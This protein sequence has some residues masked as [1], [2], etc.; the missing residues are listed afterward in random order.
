M[1][2]LLDTNV[3]VAAKQ[4]YYG[5]RL[6]PGFWEWVVKANGHGTVLS[7]KQVLD[8]LTAL[9]D[10]L[11]S[12][13][14]KQGNKLFLPMDTPTVT[15][16][17]TVTSWV[18][19]GQFRDFAKEDFLRG[20]DPFLIAYAMAHNHTI[21]TEEVFVQHTVRRV[22]IPEVCIDLGVPYLTTFEMLS[23]EGVQFVLK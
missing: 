1:A 8:E 22:R 18:M 10:D 7:H 14:S 12:W 21:V 4:R 5:F 19:K 11:A 15:A 6:C 16:M 2:Y 3:F 9:A 17:K 23:R 13:A 20:A